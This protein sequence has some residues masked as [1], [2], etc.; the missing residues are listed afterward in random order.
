[1]NEEVPCY[2]ARCKCGCGSLIFAAVDEPEASQ[3][4][5]A[6]IA[7]SVSDLITGGYVVERSTV[8]YART[9]NWLC[10]TKIASKAGVK[11][12]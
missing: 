1:M 5:K 4:L 11:S 7:K 6:D 10:A 12:P 8:E 3:R 2:I 9:A